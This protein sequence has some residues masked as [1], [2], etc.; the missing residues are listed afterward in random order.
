MCRQSSY[1]TQLVNEEDYKS[2]N[3]VKSDFVVFENFEG[4]CFEDLRETKCVYVF[5]L[6]TYCMSFFFK[7]LFYCA[8]EFWDLGV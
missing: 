6:N 3:F 2:I 4:E 1:S 8:A 7:F 5:F